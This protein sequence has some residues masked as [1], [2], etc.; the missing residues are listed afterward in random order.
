MGIA[1]LMLQHEITLVHSA[2]PSGNT[3]LHVAAENGHLAVVKVLCEAGAMIDRLNH[4]G[5]APVDLATQHSKSDV[6]Q[7]VFNMFMYKLRWSKSFANRERKKAER[8]KAG[9]KKAQRKTAR[10]R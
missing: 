3:P 4:A 10:R 8:T 5:Q 6:A 7:V 9:R 1:R 2:D